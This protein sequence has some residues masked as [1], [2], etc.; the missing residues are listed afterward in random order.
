MYLYIVVVVAA[1]AGGVG[2]AVRHQVDEQERHHGA[3]ARDYHSLRY[4][5]T[6]TL[7]IPA[8][9]IHRYHGHNCLTEEEEEEEKEELLW[10]K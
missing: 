2:S 8:I 1:V 9:C 7:D 3:Q 10:D 6:R 4:L 5:T